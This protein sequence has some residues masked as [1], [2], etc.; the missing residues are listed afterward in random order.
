MPKRTAG[1]IGATGW[2]VG[3]LLSVLQLGG[4]EVAGWILVVSIVLCVTFIGVSVAYAISPFLSSIRVDW[5]LRQGTESSARKHDVFMKISLRWTDNIGK[6]LVQVDDGK[7]R[8]VWAVFNVDVRNYGN[9]P[10]R[11]AELYLETRTAGWFRTKPFG[12]AVPVGIDSDLDWYK[13]GRGSRVEW[14]LEPQG[15]LLSHTVR[16]SQEW[17]LGAGPPDPKRFS[18]RVIGVLA[19]GDR[20]SVNVAAD[21]MGRE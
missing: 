8:S 13:N 15:E 19:N 11:L 18:A 3:L 17:A 21:I 2:G 5:P 1:G 20:I 7:V 12:K 10:K 9:T 4:I 6:P 16:F 14:P